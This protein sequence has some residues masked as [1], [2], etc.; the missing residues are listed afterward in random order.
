M[1]IRSDLLSVVDELRAIPSSSD[2]DLRRYR[3]VL[4]TR[5]WAGGKPGLGAIT[6]ADT[7]IL[8]RPKVRPLTPKEVADSGGS[9]QDGDFMVEKITPRYTSPTTGGW[10]PAMIHQRPA[11]AAQD[12]AVMLIGDEGTIECDSVKFFFERAFGY[13]MVVRAR[14]VVSG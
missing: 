3:V 8:P 9:Y 1:S 14:R 10:T 6:D 13:R 12:T 7:E 2:F 4:R 5:T 11:S